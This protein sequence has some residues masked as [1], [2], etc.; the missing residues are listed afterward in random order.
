MGALDGHT[1]PFAY[2]TTDTNNNLVLH[3]AA[4]Y[5]AGNQNIGMVIPDNYPLGT[6][7]INGTAKD[8]AG[9]ETPITLKLIVAGDRIPPII[10]P[11][12]FTASGVSMTGNLTD[13][14]TLNTDNN[15]ATTNLIQFDNTSAISKNLA[16]GMFGLTLVSTTAD[17]TELANYYNSKPEP[18]KDYLNGALAKTNPFAYIYGVGTT[19]KLADGAAYFVGGLTTDMRVPGDYPL[20]TYIVSGVIKDVAGNET[21]VTYKLIVA[22]DRVAPT[23]TV[24][25]STTN[26]TKQDVVAT[27]TPS[28][29]VTGDLTHTFTENGSFTH[30]SYQHLPSAT[31][32]TPSGDCVIP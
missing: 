17:S 29:T 12:G 30:F 9:N 19:P 4:Q 18:Y 5:D 1:H 7:T 16:S 6:Y 8:A 28:E 10:N 26:P 27:I 15:P 32:W 31:L 2:I 24:A 14:F 13:G 11:V 25:Y 23:A 21:T 22:G 20:G 3:D